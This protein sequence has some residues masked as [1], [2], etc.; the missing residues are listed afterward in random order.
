MRKRDAHAGGN[1]NLIYWC[2][3]QTNA[4]GVA[5]MLVYNPMVNSIDYGNETSKTTGLGTTGIICE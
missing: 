5:L 2:V 1:Q 3:N 4:G